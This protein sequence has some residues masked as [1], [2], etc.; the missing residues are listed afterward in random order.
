MEVIVDTEGGDPDDPEGDVQ[1][2]ELVDDTGAGDDNQ[3][4][5]T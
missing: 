4:D 2:D 3:E 1:G 5:D